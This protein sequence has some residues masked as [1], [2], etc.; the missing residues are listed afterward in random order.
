MCQKFFL[1]VSIFVLAGCGSAKREINFRESERPTALLECDQGI[2]VNTIFDDVEVESATLYVEIN[3]DNIDDS[4]STLFFY[5]PEIGVSP[6]RT[7][8]FQLLPDDPGDMMNSHFTMFEYDQDT[9]DVHGEMFNIDHGYWGV[10]HGFKDA[11]ADKLEDGFDYIG[12]T[13]GNNTILLIF[14]NQVNPNETEEEPLAVDF[15]VSTM[16]NEDLYGDQTS[17]YFPCSHNPFPW[18]T[19]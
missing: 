7:A 1:L 16:V 3:H 8:T 14:E 12:Y 9:G 10:V 13:L 5:L 11:I 2:F 15:F 18:E 19:N 4:Y 17:G 6:S